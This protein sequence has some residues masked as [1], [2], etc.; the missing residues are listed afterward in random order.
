MLQTQQVISCIEQ[1]V[2]RLLREL[3]T[4]EE[5]EESSHSLESPMGS[6]P[7]MNEQAEKRIASNPEQGSSIRDHERQL[8]GQFDVSSREQELPPSRILFSLKEFFNA[9]STCRFICKLKL[10]HL[11]LQLCIYNKFSTKRD[12]YYCMKPLMKNQA[13]CNQV[14]KELSEN[15]HVH[16][17]D[18][19]VVP[20]SRG[21][22]CGHFSFIQCN[23]NDVVSSHHT[24]LMPSS[25]RSVT[26]VSLKVSALSTCSIPSIPHLQ[27]VGFEIPREVDSLLI[28]EKE[29]VFQQLK[30]TLA[31]NVELRKF[32]LIT[33]KG[34]PDVPTRD[35]I[36]TLVKYVAKYQRR[37][38]KLYLFTD[39]DPYGAEIA[40]VYI[41]GSKSF[42]NEKKTLTLLHVDCEEECKFWV[43]QTYLNIQWLGV[44]LEE[45]LQRC[46][47]GNLEL[48]PCYK[49]CLL[50]L[51]SGDCCKIDSLLTT[52]GELEHSCCET[53]SRQLAF[54]KEFGSKVE[55]EAL[56]F[57]GVDYW[58]YILAKT[59]SSVV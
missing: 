47:E 1:Q 6:T 46:D 26:P 28:V 12:M 52:L 45:F 23:L 32:I 14:L 41:H 8:N 59:S 16:R 43:M 51:D 20:Q 19:H 58:T 36:V 15:W 10:M 50:P 31:A 25:T 37:S 48:N 38:L 13:Q 57:V 5:N 7:E 18:L 35:F 55:I 33:S 54:M 17:H 22:V 49:N 4:T 30:Q 9:Q 56:T 34:Y 42:N 2:L 24:V 44:H 40:H 11:I 21:E 53:L 39:G 27:I 29:S 3:M